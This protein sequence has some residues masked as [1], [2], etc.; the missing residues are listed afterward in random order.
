MSAAATGRHIAKHSTDWAK[1]AQ[2]VTEQH[3]A[4]FVAFRTKSQEYERKVA[5]L[6]SA[7]ASIDFESYRK[8]LPA[9]LVAAVD[10]LEKHYKTYET[11]TANDTQNLLEDIR[12]QQEKEAA[13]RKAWLVD[14]QKRVAELKAKIAWWDLLPPVE[15]MTREE[16]NQN[17]PDR[18]HADPM[19]PPWQTAGWVF[20]ELSPEW[21]A[22][23]EYAEYG[24]VHKTD[25]H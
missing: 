16:F 22:E 3:R 12:K 23:N 17:F 4:A 1:L 7:L 13:D 5:A 24:Y 15:H 11:P 8:R 19:R 2:L 6:P 10:N 20:G 25:D 18:A 21:I 9:N 14:S